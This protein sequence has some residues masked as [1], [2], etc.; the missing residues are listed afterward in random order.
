A[1]LGARTGAVV[2]L[3]CPTPA[4]SIL[5]PAPAAEPV[6]CTAFNFRDAANKNAARLI[7]AIARAGA[8]I[9]AIR[10]EI[11]G[12][13]D[14]AAF[15]ALAALADSAAPGR[16]RFLGSVPNTEIQRRFNA[17]AALALVS[18]RESYGMVFAEALLAGAPCLIPRGRAIDGYF[19]EGSVV[20]SADPKDEAEIARCLVRLLREEGAFKARLAEAGAS[21][22]LELMT[23][24]AIRDR[25]LAALA[26]ICAR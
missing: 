16:V 18:H 8:E 9:P 17:A 6:I 2:A 1:L 24:A 5:A 22:G 13:G 10:L 3:P 12:G 15:A 26:S 4:D 25:Y 21:G 19:A 7:R 14:P 23:R 11:I 20:L